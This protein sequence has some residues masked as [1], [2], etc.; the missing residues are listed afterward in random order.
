MAGRVA[1]TDRTARM[2]KP[3]RTDKPVRMD[4]P[5]RTDRMAKVTITTASRETASQISWGVICQ[6]AN[7]EV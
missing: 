6:Q 3:A 7:V 5:V 1:K 4:K 2:G